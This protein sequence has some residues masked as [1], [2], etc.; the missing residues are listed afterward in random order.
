MIHENIITFQH[1]NITVNPITIACICWLNL[2]KLNYNARNGKYRM[3]SVVFELIHA[4][5][6]NDTIL[7]RDPM[8]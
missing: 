8:C 3:R 6:T 2:Y 1:K 7:K 4:Y 5:R